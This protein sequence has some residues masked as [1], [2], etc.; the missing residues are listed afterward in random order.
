MTF[1]RERFI[2]Y[3]SRNVN[4]KGLVNGSHADKLRNPNVERG[5]TLGDAFFDVI[6]SLQVPHGWFI[7]FYVLSVLCS[8]FWLFQFCVNGQILQTL[9]SWDVTSGAQSMGM[10]Q[11]MLVWLLML[12]Q[13][14]RR[15]YESIT[16]Q[17]PSAS[18]MWVAHWA[19]GLAFYIAT[20]IGIWIEGLRKYSSYIVNI[21][22]RLVAA[23]RDSDLSVYVLTVRAPSIRTF[24]GLPLFLIASGIQHDCHSYL[25]SLKKYSLPQHPIFQKIICPHYFAEC[26]IYLSMSIIAAPPG[27]LLNNTLF[28]ALCF[29]AVNLGVTAKTTRLWYSKRFGH[30][31]IENRWTMVPFI[32]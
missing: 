13:G 32:Y 14:G 18:Q 24:I 1:I 2:A 30:T 25:A 27:R 11:V 16:L 9:I 17:K 28:T 8:L 21:T 3:G 20:S 15:L 12:I 22:L 29:V 31:S 23:L 5:T 10:D 4:S 26:L 19:I 6:A 7:H